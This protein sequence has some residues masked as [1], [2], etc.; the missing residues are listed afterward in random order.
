MDLII[1]RSQV[2]LVKG[3]SVSGGEGRGSLQSVV[4]LAKDK[5]EK[6][7]STNSFF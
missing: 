5:K 7:T 6:T 4:E 1:I 3:M 2:I